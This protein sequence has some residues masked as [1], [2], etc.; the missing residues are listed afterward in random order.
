[1]TF[2]PLEQ[3]YFKETLFVHSVKNCSR[4]VVEL[5]RRQDNFFVVL[6]FDPID[7]NCMNIL[8]S[9]EKK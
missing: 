3:R 1:M 2:S 5:L 6:I 9:T 7:F 4:H 8:C